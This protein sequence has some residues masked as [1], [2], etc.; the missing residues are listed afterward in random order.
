MS[1]VIEFMFFPIFGPNIGHV[2][3]ITPRADR[4][5]NSSSAVRC[6]AMMSFFMNIRLFEIDQTPSKKDRIY[7]ERD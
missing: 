1:H 6:T 7:A 2:S 5:L 4:M 3:I